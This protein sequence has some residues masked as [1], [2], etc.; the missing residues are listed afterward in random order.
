MMKKYKKWSKNYLIAQK[1]SPDAL[2]TKQKPCSI[3]STISLKI[4]KNLKNNHFSPPQKK[5]T[6]DF[7]LVFQKP[8]HVKSWSFL[9][10]I[11][12]F[13]TLLLSYQIQL[14]D[15]FFIFF[16]IRGDPCDFCFFWGGGQK[17]DRHIKNDQKNCEFFLH[18][19]MKNGTNKLW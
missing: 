10:C 13:R 18:I 9:C 5:L 16:I 19:R 7:L 17:V 11:Q 4:K 8:Y 2:N 6:W 12:C 15:I 3:H 14:S 1:K